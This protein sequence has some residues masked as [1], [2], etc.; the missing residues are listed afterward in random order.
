[1]NNTFH[2]KTKFPWIK[3]ELF[4]ARAFFYSSLRRAALVKVFFEA[5]TNPWE[6]WKMFLSTANQNFSGKQNDLKRSTIS[7]SYFLRHNLKT[8]YIILYFTQMFCNRKKTLLWKLGN[9]FNCGRIMFCL[10]IEKNIDYLYYFW[11]GRASVYHNN[12]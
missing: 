6:F 9:T 2:W 4:C 3:C 8:H 10:T 11:I 1:M 7:L 12:Q 5:T